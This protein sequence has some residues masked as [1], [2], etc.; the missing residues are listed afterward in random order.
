MAAT[1]AAIQAAL[2][3]G[4][5][6]KV[7][8]IQTSRYVDATYNEHYVVGLAAPY[9]GRSRWCRVTDAGNAAAQ[10]AEIVTVLTTGP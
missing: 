5:T 4:A 6:G 1:V 3:A 7:A 8:N 10:A 9:T 2:D